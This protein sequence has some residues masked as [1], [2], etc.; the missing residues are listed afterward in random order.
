MTSLPVE[1]TPVSERPSLELLVASGTAARIEPLLTALGRWFEPRAPDVMAPPPGAR[2]ASS[3]RAPG[4]AAAL[5]DTSV[6]LAVWLD[7]PT[8]DLPLDAPHVVVLVPSG[9][10][11]A[12]HDALDD[13]DARQ[14]VVP[15]PGIDARE[16]PQVAPFVRQRWRQ[17]LDLPAEL[18]VAVGVPGAPRLT[19]DLLATA[20]TT[21]SAV[22]VVGPSVLMALATGAP[23]V[24]DETTA[25]EI[26]AEQGEVEVTSIPRLLGVAGEVAADMARAAELGRRGRRLIERRHD[27][28]GVARGLADHLRALPADRRLDPTDRVRRELRALGSTPWSLP[29]RRALGAVAALEVR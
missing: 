8:P 20:F 16:H 18:V 29:G 15:V 13:D 11:D 10:V 28:G 9:R 24:T 23:V 6:P 26:G 1:G 7:D 27:L 14:V 19:P 3:C 5:D 17:R 21:A 25:R 4:L 22:A 12:D 2:L